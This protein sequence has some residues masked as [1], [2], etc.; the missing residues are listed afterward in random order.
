LRERDVAPDMTDI[1]SSKPAL[2]LRVARF[3]L[4]RLIL[5][6]GALFMMMAQ[7]NSFMARFAATPL[8]SLAVVAAMA[9]GGLALYVAFVRLVEGRPASELA[10]PALGRELG[11]GMLIGAGLYSA[12]VVI[13]MMLGIYRIEGLNP[14][15][16]MLPA[17]AMALSS[18]VFEELVFRGVLFRIVEESL[19]SWISLLVS[20]FVFG[21][22]HLINPAATVM[23]ALFI[24]IE[25]GL[26][27]AAAYMVTRRLWMSMGFHMAWNYTQSGIYSGIVSGGDS[28]PGL[29]KA[30]IEGPVALTGGSFGLESSL[31]AF[32]LCTAT[33]VVLLVIAIRRGHV[34][35]PF[36]RRAG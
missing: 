36:W 10:L 6:G 25:A 3:P 4:T 2:W 9:A 19:G 8:T 23:G 17:L 29:I 31:V 5:L 22:L 24:S 30:T 11:I 15:A 1:P 16:F 33:G 28:D 12:C 34:V 14:W 26:L 27:L 13:L 21:F 20:S 32:V 35:P 7:S 18:G